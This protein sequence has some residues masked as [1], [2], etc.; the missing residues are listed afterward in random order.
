MQLTLTIKNTENIPTNPDIERY[1][2]I[3]SALISSGGLD[4]VKGGQAILHFS[5]DG[6]F[7]GVQLDYWP[8][9]RRKDRV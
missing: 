7:M 9:R 3:V 2:E 4:G 5:P 6:T 8:W 1:S